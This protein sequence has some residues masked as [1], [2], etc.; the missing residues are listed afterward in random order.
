V[1]VVMCQV[2]GRTV[3]CKDLDVAADIPRL[4]GV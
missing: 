1:A 3:L 2:F 4:G